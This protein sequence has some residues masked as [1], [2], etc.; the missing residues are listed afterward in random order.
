MRYGGD[1][2]IAVMDEDGFSQVY[3]SIV[4]I[5][6]MQNSWTAGVPTISMQKFLLDGSGKMEQLRLKIDMPGVEPSKV[7]NLQVFA[8]F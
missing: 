1:L 6:A 5:N 8:N 2:I 4:E 7:R 3:S